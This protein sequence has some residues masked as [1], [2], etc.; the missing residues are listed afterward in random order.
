MVIERLLLI[1]PFLS[2]VPDDAPEGL[3]SPL[4]R[5]PPIDW[6]KAGNVF[7][8]GEQRGAG[9]EAGRVAESRDVDGG[10]EAEGDASQEGATG[11][12]EDWALCVGAE[13]MAELRAEV[14]RRLHY[15]CSAVSTKTS[16]IT[17]RKVTE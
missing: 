15:T 8:I 14:W 4:P 10:G 3:D 2:T 9:E 6:S 17:T 12:W 11:G 13:I 16:I 5:A 1:H 7:P